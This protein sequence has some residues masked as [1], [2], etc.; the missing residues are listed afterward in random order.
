MVTTVETQATLVPVIL[1]A[2]IKPIQVVDYHFCPLI[3]LM[4]P[5]ALGL[6]EILMLRVTKLTLNPIVRTNKYE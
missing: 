5:L 2:P 3:P 1:S 6:A 4:G